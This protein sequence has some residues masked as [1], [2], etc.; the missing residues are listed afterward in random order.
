VEAVSVTEPLVLPGELTLVLE[1]AADSIA[2]PRPD[3]QDAGLAAARVVAVADTFDA[4]THGRRYRDA[5]P[6]DFARQVLLEGRGTQFDP[7]LVDLFLFPPVFAKVQNAE[8][9]VVTWEPPV[10]K[11]KARNDDENVPDTT[12]RWR[13]GRNGSR[14]QPASDPTRQTVR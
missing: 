12:F 4:L 3:N 8:H 2:G 11:R 9:E 5:E 6:M 14:G 7:E 13:P 1:S 10:Q